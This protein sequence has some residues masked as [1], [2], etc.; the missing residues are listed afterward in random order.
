MVGFCHAVEENPIF[1]A[2]FL[3]CGGDIR[4]CLEMTCFWFVMI[5]CIMIYIDG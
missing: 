3:V 1:L 5:V 4:Y 2:L